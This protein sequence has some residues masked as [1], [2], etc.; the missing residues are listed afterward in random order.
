MSP[1]DTRVAIVQPLER[2]TVQ[3]HAASLAALDRLVLDELGPAYS[4]LP[5]QEPH[6]LADLPGKWALSH[7][8][9]DP[10]GRLAGFWI[11]S[12]PATDAHTHRVA[13]A[14]AWRSAG[15]GGALFEAVRAAARRR[16]ARR[17]TLT[18]S[19]LNAGALRFYAGLG[20]S[21]LRGEALARFLGGKGRAGARRDDEIEEAHAGACH[22]YVAL[23]LS[24]E[25]PCE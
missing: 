13:V 21:R 9:L 17:M 24:L 12:A 2:E 18:V 4:H 25:D 14:R 8:A 10:D 1:H 5:W 3:R 11:A 15:V 19:R 16:S 6:F 23:A 20:F 22:R 7:L